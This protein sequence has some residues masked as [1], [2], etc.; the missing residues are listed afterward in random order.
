MRS[1]GPGSETH[2][3]DVKTLV[4]FYSALDTERRYIDCPV[5]DR[6]T[7]EHLVGISA[8]GSLVAVGGV[9]CYFGLLRFG[10]Y[11][12]KREYQGQGH[13]TM[14]LREMIR[15]VRA[16]G[17]SALFASVHRENQASIA[18]HRRA[19]FRAIARTEPLFRLCLAF[20]WRG[21]VLSW[22]ISVLFRWVGLIRNI[23]REQQSAVVADRPSERGK[24]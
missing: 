13:G 7:L 16:T 1:T 12:V 2:P 15:Y 3:I 20:R 9:K 10:F 4:A 24:Q 8:G 19:G 5:S 22:I 17:H 21:V 11:I 23:R 14:L 18:M 6:C